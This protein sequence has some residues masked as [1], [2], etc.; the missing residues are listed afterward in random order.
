MK[1]QQQPIL[2]IEEIRIDV[3]RHARR[4]RTMVGDLHQFAVL[5]FPLIGN[6]VGLRVPFPAAGNVDVG[7]FH[8]EGVA[9]SLD[10][11]DESRPWTLAILSAIGGR[12]CAQDMTE[13]VISSELR[14]KMRITSNKRGFI[15]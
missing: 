12:C 3:L 14:A 4:L 5:V 9:N 6:R 10:L 7:T 8:I 13:E 15:M 11:P 2:V 1:G